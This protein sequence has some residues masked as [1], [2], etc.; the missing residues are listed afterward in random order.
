MIP[1]CTVASPSLSIAVYGSLRNPMTN[2]ALLSIS[3]HRVIPSINNYV[4]SLSTIL[5]LALAGS[6]IMLLGKSEPAVRRAKKVSVL[7]E[8]PS[9]FIGTGTL[10]VL[11]PEI[12]NESVVLL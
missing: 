11:M 9:S 5:A 8:N 4:P 3:F 10:I 2:S 1:I 7:S 12:L 6:S